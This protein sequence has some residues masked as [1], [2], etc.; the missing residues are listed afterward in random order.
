MDF[1]VISEYISALV[2]AVRNENV[3]AVKKILTAYP[4]GASTI[5]S[6]DRTLLH[7]VAFRQNS[8]KEMMQYLLSVIPPNL[9]AVQDE[10]GYS[11]LHV[12]IMAKK[13]DFVQLLYS[14]NPLIAY[15]REY[16]EQRTPLEIA[17]AVNHLPTVNFLL[18]ANPDL[19]YDCSD[20][21]I[22][23]AANCRMLK[24]L[25]D[26]KPSLKFAFT[27]CKNTLLHKAVDSLDHKC[28]ALLLKMQPTMIFIKNSRNQSP[29]QLALQKNN[30]KVVK[31]LL[32]HVPKHFE[33][34]KFG[35]NSLHAAVTHCSADIIKDVFEHNHC[36]L[37]LTNSKNETPF[38]L[39]ANHANFQALDL[40]L[41]HATV[42]MVV[43]TRRKSF[44]YDDL[45]QF[46]KTQCASLTNLLLPELNAIVFHLLGL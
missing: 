24:R 17:V 40:F 41:P 37:S 11:A 45:Q 32:L 9:L 39:A 34:D 38:A 42:E 23:N 33:M 20:D 1:P 36:Y 4:N 12:A 21:I 15:T 7:I 16:L 5:T 22:F 3:E 19:I 35:N 29:L 31:A 8:G 28:V 27:K 14:A 30:S 2:K 6:T 25:L 10:R 26:A 18:A 13:F 46:V 44:I 43:E